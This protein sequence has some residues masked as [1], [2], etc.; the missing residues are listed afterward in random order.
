VSA[1]RNHGIAQATG[2]YVTFLDSDDLMLEHRVERQLAGLRETG[3]DA[4]L[5]RK[6]SC[7]IGGVRAPEWM[8]R[9]PEWWTG[10]FHASILLPTELAEQIGGFDEAL[11]IG[12]DLDFVARLVGAGRRVGTIDEV[13]VVRRLFGDNASYAIHD[14]DFGALFG[15]V[16]RH[17]SR[18]LRSEPPGGS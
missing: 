8:E 10:P 14:D 7:L 13:L 6:E 4:V 9:H 18:A 17:R 1:A 3:A 12:E 16:R 11:S 15:A 2:E 5:C